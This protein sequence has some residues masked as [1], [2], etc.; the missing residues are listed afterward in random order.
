M[1]N[2]VLFPS[3]TQ[4]GAVMVTKAATPQTLTAQLTA[5]LIERKMHDEHLPLIV[6]LLH[7]GPAKVMRL[8]RA[9]EGQDA[10]VVDAKVQL[11]APVILQQASSLHLSD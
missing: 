3:H 2:C 7:L 6:D 10:A 4:L 1:T 8:A 5:D 9:L 11:I